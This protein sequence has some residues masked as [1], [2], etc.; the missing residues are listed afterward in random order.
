LTRST[1]RFIR[2]ATHLTVLDIA[3]LLA[4]AIRRLH[5]AEPLAGLA[6]SGLPQDR[7]SLQASA[8]SR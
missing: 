1:T 6:G 8:P 4:E 5:G 3:P 7:P 2:A